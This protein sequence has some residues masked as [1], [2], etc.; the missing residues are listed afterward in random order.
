MELLTRPVEQPFFLE[1]LQMRLHMATENLLPPERQLEGRALE[2]IDEDE[3]ILGV[4]ARVLGRCP[5]EII[6]MCRQVLVHGR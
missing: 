6:G 1:R 4:D 5:E 2:V 3:G